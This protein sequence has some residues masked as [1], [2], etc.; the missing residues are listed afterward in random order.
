M[1]LTSNG[2]DQAR[3]GVLLETLSSDLGEFTPAVTAELL[4]DELH[5]TPRAPGAGLAHA[6][7]F[8]PLGVAGLVIECATSRRDG[9]THVLW[10]DPVTEHALGRDKFAQLADAMCTIAGVDRAAWENAETLHLDA[11]GFA[12]PDLL[13]QA[14]SAIVD[15]FHEPDAS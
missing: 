9:F 8:R 12:W 15:L 11:P 2:L 14:R 10:M 3:F 13:V 6:R 5:L 1:T 4:R 7:A